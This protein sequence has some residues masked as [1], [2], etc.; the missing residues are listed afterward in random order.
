[1]FGQCNKSPYLRY[2][3]RQEKVAINLDDLER[4]LRTSFQNALSSL[5]TKYTTLNDLECILH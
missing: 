3:A 2:G 5:T 4:P 1:M